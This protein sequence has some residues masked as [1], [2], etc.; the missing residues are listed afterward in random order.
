MNTKIF[1]LGTGAA[2]PMKRMLPCICLKIDSD[3]YV[4]DMGE[5]C[6]R[7]MLEMGLSPVKIKAI[8]ITHLHG[9]HYLG[10]FGLLQ[11]MHLMSREK[12]LLIIGPDRLSGILNAYASNG[13][14]NIDFP[15]Y[16][17]PLHEGLVYRDEK[18]DVSSFLVDHIPSSYGFVINTRNNKKIVYT[19]DTRPCKSIVENAA[20]ADVLIHEATFTSDMAYEA[21]EQGHSTALDAATAASEANAKLL[22]LTHI[23][24][25][26]D[27][28][29]VLLRDASRVYYS[30]VVAEDRM[31]IYL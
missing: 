22:V 1:M 27:D 24:A 12:E 31:V 7:T 16:F 25:R 20:N 9:D 8:F 21:H 2:I 4:F 17:E 30:V 28:P 10:I 6:Q 29:L 13:L 23:S 11:T 14:L 18:L 3:L 5:G 19:G 15:L 26:Y